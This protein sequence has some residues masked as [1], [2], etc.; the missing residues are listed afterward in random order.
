MKKEILQQ[1]PWNSENLREYSEN[2]HSKK[3]ENLEEMDT[4]LDVFD[5][6]KF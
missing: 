1:I 5:L 4:F 3:L 6:T 2:V